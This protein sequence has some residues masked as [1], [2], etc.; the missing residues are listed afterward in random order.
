MTHASDAV[1]TL[2]RAL[3][4]IAARQKVSALLG[5]HLDHYFL[6]AELDADADRVAEVAEELHAA[7]VQHF[8]AGEKRA[9]GQVVVAIYNPEFDRQGGQSPHTAIDIIV[10]DMSFLVDS[11]TMLTTERGLTV[12]R[13]LHPQLGVR[14][15]AQG[16]LTHSGLLSEPGVAAE[17]WMHLEID[18]VSDPQ[19]MAE[20]RQA[21]LDVLADVRAAVE[22]RT[23]MQAR[24]RDAAAELAGHI[25]LS[26]SRGRKSGQQQQKAEQHLHPPPQAPA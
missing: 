21:L 13:L 8:R 26:R 7:A 17:S 14:R 4:E 18:R 3:L 6:D 25:P 15:D 12:H 22:D 19:V 24:M 23:A 20:L 16:V 10:D 9:A 11:V 5:A 2:R 1:G